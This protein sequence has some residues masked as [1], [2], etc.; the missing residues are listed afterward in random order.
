ML[1]TLQVENAETLL[2][3]LGDMDSREEREAYLKVK[4][5]RIYIQ[6]LKAMKKNDECETF[7][8][9][10]KEAPEFQ[11]V[12]ICDYLEPLINDLRNR[13]KLHFGKWS[14]HID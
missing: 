5:A 4:A 12:Y 7:C 3:R 1:K 11:T 6:G 14:F 9:G 8:Q 2:D 10:L 13:G